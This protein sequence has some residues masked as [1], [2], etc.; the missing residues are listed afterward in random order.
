MPDKPRGELYEDRSFLPVEPT[1]ITP[2]TLLDQLHEQVRREAR[3]KIMAKI[4]LEQE[5]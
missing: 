1:K 5:K 3:D 4:A 2:D